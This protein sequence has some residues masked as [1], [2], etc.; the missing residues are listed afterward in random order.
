MLRVTLIL[1]LSVVALS[2]K[3]S[4]NTYQVFTEKINYEKN[5]LTIDIEYPRINNHSYSYFQF[6]L[7]H[8]FTKMINDKIDEYKKIHKERKEE[9]PNNEFIFTEIHIEL[10]ILRKNKILSIRF[11]ELG[12]EGGTHMSHDFTTIN[13]NMDKMKVYPL[14]D[15]L[16]IGSD[17]ELELLKTLINSALLS[18]EPDACNVII[19]VDKSH[20]EHFNLLPTGISF[21]LN[22]ISGHACGESEVL[23]SYKSLKAQNLLKIDEL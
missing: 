23:V 5:G 18:K 8:A 21:V 12:F 17:Y 10:K 11:N 19:D 2:F 15:V 20:F 14:K 16:D 4:N 3:T 7:N 9:D 13:I 1:F 6:V 22:R